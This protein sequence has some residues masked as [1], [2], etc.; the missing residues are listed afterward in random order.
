MPLQGDNREDRRLDIIFSQLLRTNNQCNSAQVRSVNTMI[1]QRTDNIEAI[2]HDI[3]S[4]QFKINELMNSMKDLK[5]ARLQEKKEIGRCKY[6]L[7]PLR[8]LPPELLTEIFKYTVTVYR[9]S[10]RSESP[11]ALAHVCSA[12]RDAVFGCSDFWNELKLLVG[13]HTKASP[14]VFSER[15]ASW[16]GHSNSSHPL[17]LSIWIAGTP[18]DHIVLADLSQSIV[19]F[20]PRL[21]KLSLDFMFKNYDALIPFLC[22]PP[23]SFPALES[24]RL[25]AY[26][27]Y[28]IPEADE[29]NDTTLLPPATVFAAAPCLRTLYLSI[30]SHLLA[31]PTNL[32]FPWAQLTHLEI[33]YGITFSTFT[34]IL[35][36][37]TLHL[38]TA[39]F[40]RISSFPDRFA[41]A[42]PPPMIPSTP[43]T[44]PH[45]KHLRL[46]VMFIDPLAVTPT[47]V[48]VLPLLRVPNLQTLEVSSEY[49]T[50]PVYALLPHLAEP[51]GTA[52][53]RALS[54]REVVL[55]HVE[56]EVAELVGF[57]E[58]CTAVEKLGL[59]VESV[60]PNEILR[61]MKEMVRFS[62]LREFRFVFSLQD[63][64]GEDVRGVGKDFGALVAEWT[65]CGGGRRLRK[66]ALYVLSLLKNLDKEVLRAMGE[67][68]R[69][70]T[71][72]GDEEYGAAAHGDDR[73]S[74]RTARKSRLN[75]K[76]EEMDSLSQVQTMFGLQKNSHYDEDDYLS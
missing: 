63:A 56:V 30:P 29:P 48:N 52:E 72:L 39:L 24:L 40:A 38:Q 5:D 66:V 62:H 55:C 21:V 47:M 2:D 57:L 44:F 74:V 1:A 73:V 22:L 10:H 28:P 65:K 7:S 15:V 12:W 18:K 49:G 3:C 59:F 37:R 34:H 61:R 16:Y 50:F 20:S 23:D 36:Q 19:A 45:L 31:D 75:V 64:Q 54:L 43:Q 6:I 69:A 53:W 51:G 35:F 33:D 76:V 11:L 25:L 46:S 60:S 41:P 68:V 32:R 8:L 4:I 13:P 27:T 14:G 42:P 67:D 26:H 9:P 58:R 70:A 71:L 17:R